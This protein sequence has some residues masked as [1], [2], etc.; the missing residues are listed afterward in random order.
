[1][2]HVYRLIIS[3]PDQV[4]I[5]AKVAS[6]IAEQGGLIVE[7]NHHT[8]PADNWFFMRHEILAS[9]IS[10]SFEAFEKGFQA[11]ADAFDMTWYISDSEKPKKIA[12][13]ASKESH[14]LAD[15][16][17]RWHDSELPGEIVCVIA[18]HDDLRS[19]V[20]WYQVPFHHVPVT[21]DTKPE[22]FAETEALAKKY[23]AD[24]IVLARYMQILP[25]QMCSDYAGQVIN[26]HHSF[27]PSFIGAKPYHQASARG[28]KLIGATCHY[29]TEEL[30]EGPIIEQDVIRVNHSKSIEDLKRLGRDVEKTVLARGLR[31][32]LEDRV[33]IHGNK[34]VVFDS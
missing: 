12:L 5:V 6:Y 26:I 33:L 4:G 3:C 24:M 15:L 22:A 18:N 16:L 2:R 28:V 32:H 14:C 17:H 10:D 20:E 27:L 25:P 9:S 21:A 30:D 29:V 8:D 34:T 1:M 31:Y 19:M 11:V 23:G 7:A 13:F